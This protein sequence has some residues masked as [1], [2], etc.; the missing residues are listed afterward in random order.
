MRRKS[1][2]V[3]LLVV[4][5]A[6]GCGDSA[7]SPLNQPMAASYSKGGQPGNPSVPAPLVVHTIA[8]QATDP[9]IDQFL[10]NHYALLDTSVHSMHRLLVFMGGTGQF[11]SQFLLVQNEAA[12]L[13]YHVIGLEYV[14]SGGI[15]KICPPTTDP[16]ACFENVRLEVI[17]GVDRTPLITVSP[18]N[19]ID[20]RLDKLLRFLVAQYPRE[21]WSQYIDHK[22]PKWTRIA[23]A[24]LSVGGGEAAMIAKLRLV[25]RVVM[26]SSVPD[27]IGK[28]SVPWVAQHRTPSNRYY[29]LAHNRDGFFVPILASWD[30]LGLAAFGPSTVIDGAHA[31]YGHTHM[32]VTGITPVGGF[33]GLNAHA[34]TATDAFT[35]LAV[36]GT[37]LLLEAW[38]YMLSAESRSR[39]R[40]RSQRP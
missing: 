29:G 4:V 21:H 27:S 31:P 25:D 38:R 17:D 3:L 18:A 2:C 11:P 6:F 32:L 8:P 7:V 20:N 39:Q 5:A 9:A 16:A 12:R 34:S 13:G 1:E 35:A 40:G 15:A 10:D 22:G 36:D 37:P 23:V 28:Q 30:S 33:V 19:S 26:F 24:G 14:N